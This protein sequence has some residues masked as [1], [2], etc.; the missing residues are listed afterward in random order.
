MGLEHRTAIPRLCQTP[1]VAFCTNS[2]CLSLRVPLPGW[3]VQGSE[4]GKNVH[5]KVWGHRCECVVGGSMH[6]PVWLEG[7]S[8]KS[9]F[10]GWSPLHSLSP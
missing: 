2:P 7:V 3:E 8:P 1:S 6:M 4:I 10:L 9:T 5:I